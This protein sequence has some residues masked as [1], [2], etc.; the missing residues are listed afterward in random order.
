MTRPLLIRG[1]RAVFSQTYTYEQGATCDIEIK[2]NRISRMGSRLESSDALI[3][4]GHSCVAIPGLANTHHHFYQ[5]LTRAI[6]RMQN[7]PLFPWLVDHYRVWE[8]ISQEAVYWSSLAAI[9]ELLLTGCTLTTDHHYLFPCDTA[10]DLI[11]RQISAARKLGIRFLATRGSMSVGKSKG[12][13][14]PDGVIQTEQQ[15]LD[16]SIRLIETFHDPSPDSMQR[17]ALAPCSPFS[18]SEELMMETA[19][20]AREN[21]VRLHTHLAETLDEEKYCIRRF[22]CRPVELMR[23]LNWL[24]NDV[25]FAHCVHLNDEE[26]QLFADTGSGTAHCPSSNMRLG[27]GIAPIRELVAAGAPVGIAVDGS[28]SNDGSDMLGEV[29]QA[30]LLQRVTKGAD[31]MTVAEA[32]ELGSKGGYRMLGFDQ[33]GRLEVGALADIAIFRTDS[34]DYTG[35]HDPVGGLILAGDCHR[36]EHVFVNGKQVVTNGRLC[37][38]DEK[39]IAE[40]TNQIASELLSRAGSRNN[41]NYLTDR[42]DVTS[43]RTTR[44]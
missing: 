30:M 23:R 2:D 34:L 31:A 33:G 19:R 10:G 14:P 40:T 18:V 26:I 1:L 5:V 27:S 7:A 36:A 43:D 28:A 8:G 6:P 25:W 16:D 32:F 37:G 9:G 42:S 38:M 11:D 15:I 21:N 24:G 3:I 13:L 29:R 44:A 39:D 12:G 35:I 41:V 20:V 17:I 4:D 22:H